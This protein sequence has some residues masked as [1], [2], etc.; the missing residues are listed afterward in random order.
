LSQTEPEPKP[1]PYQFPLL[2]QRAMTGARPQHSVEGVRQAW[3]LWG[4][5]EGFV[6]GGARVL[7]TELVE[8]G[9]TVTAYV[10]EG[11]WVADCP[12]CGSGIATWPSNPDAAC[13]QCGTVFRAKHPSPAVVREAEAA[14]LSRPLRNRHWRP[15]DESP[16]TLRQENIRE[17][18]RPSVEGFSLDQ[19]PPPPGLEKIVRD[20][21]GEGSPEG[22]K[23]IARLRREGLL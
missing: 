21:L 17:G 5:T 23:L 2:D 22:E 6:R 20:Q 13:L 18:Y 19:I 10:N 11:R 4:A 3:Q 16:Q 7:T 8:T 1:E 9:L 14:L 12:L 15:A